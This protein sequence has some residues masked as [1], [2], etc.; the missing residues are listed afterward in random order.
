MTDPQLTKKRRAD[1][2]ASILLLVLSIAMLAETLTFPMTDSY[3]GVSNV[4]YVSPALFPL[5]VSSLLIVLALVLMSRAIRDGGLS[6]ALK[7]LPELGRFLATE[8]LHRLLVLIS[9]ISAY[10]YALVPN[11][12]FWIAS[13]AFLT[14]LITL[15]YIDDPKV[16]RPLFWP[17]IVVSIVVFTIGREQAVNGV[18]LDVIVA[19]VAVLQNLLVFILFGK[20]PA[21]FK[22]WRVSVLSAVLTPLVLVPAF[23]FGLLVPLPVEGLVINAMSDIY[24]A[25]GQLV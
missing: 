2:I 18:T 11:I 16:F 4:W 19:V 15:F 5:L 13:F 6:Q 1:L 17:F 12:D 8:N 25:I 23:K 14:V 9:L 21:Y 20:N 22:K 10:V 3:G 24:R 7:D